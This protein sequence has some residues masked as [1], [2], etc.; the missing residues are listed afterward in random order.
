MKG[1]VYSLFDGSGIM[2]L[3]WAESGYQVFCFNSDNGDHGKYQIKMRHP[4]LTYVNCWIDEV[5][6]PQENY[7]DL[8]LCHPIGK[9]DI[10]FAFPDCTMLTV[11]GAQHERSEEAIQKS[12]ANAKLVEDLG[13]K[14]NCPWMVENPVGK[15]SALWRKPDYYFDPY[16]YGGYISQQDGSFHV[17]MPYQDGYTKKTCLWVGNGFIMPEKKPVPHI[18]FFWAWRWCGGKGAKTKQLRSL[19]PRGFARAVYEA[20]KKGVI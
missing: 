11:A 19:T 9:P 17:R 12:I 8:S 20:N 10:I 14:Y 18:G 4:N 13:V 7:I 6:D 3:P 1:I 16:E 15:M 5:F 2:G